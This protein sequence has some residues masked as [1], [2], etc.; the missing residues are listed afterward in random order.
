MLCAH[1]KPE[2]QDN[3]AQALRFINEE[4]LAHEI[5]L[6]TY[7]PKILEVRTHDARHL[8]K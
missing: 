5:L 3:P 2:K 8:T 6:C 7:H 1:L 4:I